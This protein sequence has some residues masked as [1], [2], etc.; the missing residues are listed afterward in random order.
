MPVSISA[1]PELTLN[2]TNGGPGLHVGLRLL[3]TMLGTTGGREGHILTTVN[4]TG[5]AIPIVLARDDLYAV[6]F[7][8]GGQWFRFNDAV[9]PFTETVTP[10][11]YDGQYSALGGLTGDPA[12]G[13]IT[14]LRG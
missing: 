1:L 11:G 9:W 6:G 13:S 2:Y 10:L 3:E 5:A 4:V 8:C 14:A 12:P 7:R